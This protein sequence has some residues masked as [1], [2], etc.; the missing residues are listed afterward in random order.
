M[1]ISITELRSATHGAVS[2][3]QTE[4]G[5]CF[6]RMTEAQRQYYLDRGDEMH[7][8]NSLHSAGVRLAFRTNSRSLTLS[9]E[10]LPDLSGIGGSF[11]IWEDG[12][13]IANL[14]GENKEIKDLGVA[15]SEGEHLVEIYFPWSKGVILQELSLDDGTT[16]APYGESGARHSGVYENVIQ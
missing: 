15:L 10:L 16:F 5:I 8:R 14:G 2:L 9:A 3:E 6:W 4:S 1:T 13:L 12:V 7:I 11:D